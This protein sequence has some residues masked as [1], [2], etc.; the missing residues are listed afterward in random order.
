MKKAG[1]GCLAGVILFGL[2]LGYFIYSQK[3]KDNEVISNG[4]EIVITAYDE[5]K[6]MIRLKYEIGNKSFDKSTGKEYSGI[7]DGEQF[8]GLYL[9]SDPESFLV[10]FDQP[11]LSDKYNY[12][13]TACLSVTKELSVLKFTYK[14]GDERFERRTVYNE[15]QS[16]SSSNYIVKYRIEN[17]KIGY[18]ISKE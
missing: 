11:F 14:V 15:N 13:E 8:R 6:R 18:L 10:F 7:E 16:L 2:V 4:E 17:P 5:G 1:I 12:Q 3:E 9:P